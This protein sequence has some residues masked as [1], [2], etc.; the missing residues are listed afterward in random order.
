[1]LFLAVS[2]SSRVAKRVVPPVLEFFRSFFAE[3]EEEEEE[4][5]E[6]AYEKYIR[7]VEAARTTVEAAGEEEVRAGEGIR[8]TAGRY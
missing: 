1:M 5:R 2:R 3:E 4:A 6:R 8:P 7:E